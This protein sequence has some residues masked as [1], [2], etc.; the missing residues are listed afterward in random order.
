VALG[1]WNR[2][3]ESAATFGAR[4]ADAPEGGPY[5]RTGDLGFLHDG[6]LYP[7]AR[8][9]EL[10]IFW[11]RNVYPQDVE[12]TVTRC[13]PALK[14]HGGAAFSVEVDGSERLVVVQEVTAA[15]R[16]DLDELA[17]S[18]RRAV[19]LDHRVPLHALVLLKPGTLPKTSSGKIQRLEARDRYLRGGLAVVRRWDFGTAAGAV[20]RRAEESEPPD[21]GAIRDWLCARVAAHCGLKADAIDATR[22]LTDYVLDSV[23]LVALAV[24]LEAWL[25]G[26]V[27][28]ATI[29]D[30]PSAA[31]LARRLAGLTAAPVESPQA[32]DALS[33]RDVD[34]A[35]ADLLAEAG[36]D[37]GTQR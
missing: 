21:E 6:E 24:E 30:A 14:E 33:E 26:P 36:A 22:P 31:E 34:R 37:G 8:L 27:E 4:L 16:P 10:L 18:I 19:L 15:G 20:F 1:Y 9:K 23:T 25:G 32:V 35:L 12:A 29:F 17:V 28:P 13:H 7:V 11:G 2:P 3:E 5:L